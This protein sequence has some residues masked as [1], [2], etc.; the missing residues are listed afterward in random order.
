MSRQGSRH[1]HPFHGQRLVQPFRTK[2]GAGFPVGHHWKISQEFPWQIEAVRNLFI[3]SPKNMTNQA[4][5]S[6]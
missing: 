4:V 6:S 1:V 3:H 5:S 2:T